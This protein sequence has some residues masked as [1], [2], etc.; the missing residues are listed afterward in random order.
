MNSHL[1]KT[2]QIIILVITIVPHLAVVAIAT[3][4][5]KKPRPTTIKVILTN[6]KFKTRK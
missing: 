5:T 4:V 3:N 1:D 2:S 6:N